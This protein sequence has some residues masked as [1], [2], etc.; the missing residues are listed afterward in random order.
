M[1][2]CLQADTAAELTRFD[3]WQ[4]LYSVNPSLHVILQDSLV[5][6]IYA[7]W[8]SANTSLETLKIR[9][10]D[11][12]GVSQLIAAEKLALEKKSVNLRAERQ[13]LELKLNVY[14][15]VPHLQPDKEGY[16]W[17]WSRFS[18]KRRFFMVRDGN[19]VY[20]KG[21]KQIVLTPLLLSKVTLNT[22]HEQ[23]FALELRSATQ[24]KTHTLLAE[25]EVYAVEWVH[26]LTVAS[27]QGL[28]G[29]SSADFRCADCG[30]RGAEWCSLNLCVFLCIECSGAH[31]ALGTHNSKVR[32]LQLDRLRAETRNL[33]E[34]LS[35]R[36]E[37]VW[38]SSR[39]LPR[40]TLLS[41][42]SDRAAL[43][44]QKYI[45]KVGLAKIPFPEEILMDAVSAGNL[46]LALRCLHSVD[47]IESL[48][49]AQPFIHEAA[50]RGNLQM[51]ELFVLNGFSPE[52]K[53]SEGCTAAEVALLTKQHAAAAYLLKLLD[54]KTEV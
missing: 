33:I 48:Q 49:S 28:L 22:S 27:E 18:W 53:D 7:N 47:S 14:Q 41:P 17:K 45:E 31:R 19:L 8:S 32:S 5:A 50:R 43:A 38:E 30:I 40:P 29:D 4:A 42:A 15:K 25:N 24:K 10:P 16:L 21:R 46:V 44:R 34:K 37:E 2:K 9:S 11:I 13:A 52:A 54:N 23:L 12:D 20:L 3:Y 39:Q 36:S 6:L 1:A 26:T 51:L 35:E